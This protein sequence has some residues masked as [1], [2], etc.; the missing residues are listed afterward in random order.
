M[1]HHTILMCSMLTF[2]MHLGHYRCCEKHHIKEYKRKQIPLS[3]PLPAIDVE[4]LQTDPE[5]NLKLEQIRGTHP[6]IMDL[7]GDLGNSLYAEPL[8]MTEYFDTMNVRTL[9]RHADDC[10]SL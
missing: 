6:G 4:V 8:S 10:M 5:E 7:L 1:G 2:T 9:Q 3:T